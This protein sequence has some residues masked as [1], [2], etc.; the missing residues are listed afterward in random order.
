MVLG[1]LVVFNYTVEFELCVYQ[2]SAKQSLLAIEARDTQVT[3]NLNEDTEW[4]G[5]R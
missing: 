1:R 4:V 2:N 5:F 3:T